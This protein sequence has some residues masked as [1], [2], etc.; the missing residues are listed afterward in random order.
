MALAVEAGGLVKA[1]W[2]LLWL[3][4]GQSLVPAGC[5]GGAEG[6]HCRPSVQVYY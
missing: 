2:E 3:Q 5:A 6:K 1:A 4:V